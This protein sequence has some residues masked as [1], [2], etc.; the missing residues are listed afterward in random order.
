MELGTLGEGFLGQAATR[1]KRPDRG[2]EG[3]EERV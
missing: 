2:S 3:S 1:P